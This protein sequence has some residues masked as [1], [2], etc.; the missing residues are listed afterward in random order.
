MGRVKLP[1]ELIVLDQRLP[2]IFRIHMAASG[3]AL[4]LATVAFLL[5]H[6]P[7]WHR[8][9]GRLASVAVIA[10]GITALPSALLS[11]A[12]AMARAGF[13]AQGCVWLALLGTG[14]VEI[15]A[16]RIDTHRRAMLGMLAVA[17]GAVVLR[18]AM[19]ATA[20]LQLPYAESYA[21]LAWA[22]W[23]MPLAVVWRLTGGR[24]AGYGGYRSA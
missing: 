6:K 19:A 17:S 4:I 22:S 3:L 7:D 24:R 9:I 21:F 11:E 8:P 20:G 12:T 1:Y 18:F 14:L 16:R 10:G 5:R 23:L 13:F 15:R 2:T